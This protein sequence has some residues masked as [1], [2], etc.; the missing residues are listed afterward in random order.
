MACLLGICYELFR[1]SGVRRFNPGSGT[2]RGRVVIVLPSIAMSNSGYGTLYA[3]QRRDVNFFG[4]V[5]FGGGLPQYSRS[6]ATA[7]RGAPEAFA[8]G[9][10]RRAPV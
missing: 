9:A 6:E 5:L 8:P 10:R 3:N 4:M 1:L 7:P 2:G